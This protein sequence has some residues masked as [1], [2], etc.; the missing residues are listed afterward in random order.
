M[1][2]KSNLNPEPSLLYGTFPPS[3]NSPPALGEGLN[4][5][6]M[7]LSILL[8][9]TGVDRQVFHL[10]LSS[11]W[12]QDILKFQ[13]GHKT[14]KKKPNTYNWDNEDW[15]D[16]VQTPVQLE[17]WHALGL[18]FLNV[19]K[20][21]ITYFLSGQKLQGDKYDCVLRYLPCDLLS[22]MSMAV[23][24]LTLLRRH[25]MW[26]HTKYISRLKL[27]LT[28]Y[29]MVSFYCVAKICCWNYGLFCVRPTWR[30]TSTAETSLVE[31][32]STIILAMLLGKNHQISS[33]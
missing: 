15:Q 29:T 13:L 2:Q 23:A 16:T 33:L 18:L 3:P 28:F 32:D 11:I 17:T 20:R 14:S 12:R 10:H 5:F 31:K 27:P 9:M 1:R 30:T 8:N 24:I 26:C 7:G 25:L 4:C 19:K 21:Q 6:N 22:L